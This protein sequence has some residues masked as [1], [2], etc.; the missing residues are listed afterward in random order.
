MELTTL[1]NIHIYVYFHKS[2]ERSPGWTTPP[3]LSEI[4]GG[5]HAL[6]PAQDGVLRCVVR[7]LLRGD[8]QHGRDGLHVGV[9]R[10]PD[11]LGDELVDEDNTDISTSQE[12]PVW[13]M[14]TKHIRAKKT[15]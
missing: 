2:R 9:Y 14:N 6:G 10:M 7:M 15:F 11:H 12:T 13:E 4:I 3:R 1:H 5:E 8:L